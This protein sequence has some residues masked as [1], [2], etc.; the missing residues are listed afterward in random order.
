MKTKQKL[1]SVKLRNRIIEKFK[2]IQDIF[3]NNTI[4]DRLYHGLPTSQYII[5]H[6]IIETKLH[7]CSDMKLIW[8]AAQSDFCFTAGDHGYT[9][10][11]NI[12]I[13]ELNDLFCELRNI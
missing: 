1:L 11:E 5:L 2:R 6:R 9:Q 4:T 10:E 12:A 8:L 3:D 13:N 7:K